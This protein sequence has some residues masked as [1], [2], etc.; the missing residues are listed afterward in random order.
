MPCTTARSC[1]GALTST[2]A[3][4]HGELSECCYTSASILGD[5]EQRP[6]LFTQ[7]QLMQGTMSS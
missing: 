2:V 7:P 4:N 5:R 6:L 3:C 1:E